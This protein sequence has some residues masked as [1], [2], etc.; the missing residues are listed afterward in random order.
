MEHERFFA[1]HDP[2]QDS[3]GEVG[4]ARAALDVNADSVPDLVLELVDTG[5]ND[6]TILWTFYVACG[7]TG[8][9][10]PVW[11]P[12]YLE[13]FTLA[14]TCTT[15]DSICWRDV[16]VVRSRAHVRPHVLHYDG[17]SYR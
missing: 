16:R 7:A 11:G 4:V 14:S 15:V 12:D 13:S 9:Y 8:T 17:A 1:I 6:G 10:R 3:D 5:G 2:G